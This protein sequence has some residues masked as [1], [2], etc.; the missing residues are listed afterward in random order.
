[1]KSEQCGSN[2]LAEELRNQKSIHIEEIQET[3]EHVV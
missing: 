2:L 1:M 3:S